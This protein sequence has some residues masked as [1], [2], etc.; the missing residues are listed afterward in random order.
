MRRVRWSPDLTNQCNILNIKAKIAKF[1]RR[2]DA[3]ALIREIA[4][5]RMPEKRA[6]PLLKELGKKLENLNNVLK[7]YSYQKHSYTP[8]DECFEEH[9]QNPYETPGIPEGFAFDEYLW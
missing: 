1:T 4:E 9:G 8:M 5:L 7:D 2:G 6:I 3:S